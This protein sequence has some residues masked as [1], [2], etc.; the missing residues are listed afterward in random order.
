MHESVCERELTW[1]RAGSVREYAESCSLA[2]YP[3]PTI[4]TFQVPATAG[5]SSTSGCT[6]WAAEDPCRTC[7]LLDLQ[8]KAFRNRRFHKQH[9]RNR[10][11]TSGGSRDSTLPAAPCVI[12]EPR[13]SSQCHPGKVQ[14]E[15]L[16]NIVRGPVRWP[17]LT[18]RSLPL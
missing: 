5:Q 12:A 8:E 18:R 16:S 15:T 11:K 7:K 2:G 3:E 10:L 6:V 1:R 13:G 4:R 17:A 9:S 14:R